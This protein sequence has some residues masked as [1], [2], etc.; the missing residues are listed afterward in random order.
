MLKM[1]TP[2]NAKRGLSEAIGIFLVLLAVFLLLSPT[3]AFFPVAYGLVYVFGLPL[4]YVLLPIL[5]FVGVSFLLKGR[6]S[7]FK[8]GGWRLLLGA[9]LLYLSL[10][11]FL[12]YGG[13]SSGIFLDGE[14]YLTGLS[15]LYDVEMATSLYSSLAVG[16][17]YPL[18]L[19]SALL[20]S[21]AGP[22]LV[23]TVASVLLVIAVVTFVY[24]YALLYI[25]RLPAK[26]KPRSREP[27]PSPTPSREKEEGSVYFAEAP[28]LVSGDEEEAVGARYA[29]EAPSI[30]P[31]EVAPSPLPSYIAP[32][33]VANPGLHE[34][35][36]AFPEGSGGNEE[37]KEPVTPIRLPDPPSKE[38]SAPAAAE[39]RQ[40]EFA[41]PPLPEPGPSI[42]PSD[43]PSPSYSF[44]LDPEPELSA[45]P[46]EKE[47][48]QPEEEPEVPVEEAP[49]DESGPTIGLSLDELENGPVEKPVKEKTPG[50]PLPEEDVERE[51]EPETV[52]EE[53]APPL[54]PY[55]RLGQRK[56]KPLPPYVFPSLDLLK[57]YEDGGDLDSIRSE[58]EERAK[59]ITQTLSD[60]RV[61]ARVVSYTIG[62]SVTRYDIQC[63]P[64][65]PVATIGKYVQDISVRLSGVP[66]RFEEVVRG[67]ATSGLEIANSKTSIVSLREMIEHLPIGPKK[68]LYI[69]FGK[70]ISGEYISADLGEFPHML[71]AGGTGSGKSI[72][73]H[74]IIMS[75]LMRNRPEELKF[76]LIDPKR[77]ELG[78]YRDVPHLLTHMIKD[79]EEAK[80]CLKKLCDEM[81]RRYDLLEE[82][83]ISNIRQFNSDIAEAEGLEKLPFIVVV[84]DEYADLVGNCKEIGD[85]VVRLAQ[86]ARAAGIH[87]VIATQRPSVDIITG[88]IKANLQVRVA[89]RVASSQDSMVILSQGGA[90]DL[91]GYGDM[92]VD[93]SLVSRSGFTR[94][95]GCMVDN[96]EIAAVSDF[97]SS[98]LKCHYDPTFADLTDHEADAKLLEEGMS[99]DRAA[100]KVQQGDDFYRNVVE[101]IIPFD[102]TS[103]SKI[104]RQFGIGFPRAG[105]IFAHLQRD[106]IVSN[107]MVSPQKGCPVLVHTM[108]EAEKLMTSEAKDD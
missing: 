45:P 15:A 92:L 59:T 20:S 103:I 33:R 72:F 50:E 108:E 79:T 65:V 8:T 23:V 18:S 96:R 3:G 93:C 47:G 34:A 2:Q 71:I 38:E 39:E 29:P 37:R 80:V 27:D 6:W 77:V 100:L 66:T 28:T 61:G 68:N 40:A 60:L 26:G 78:K 1:K 10:A 41:P 85:Y 35:R 87:L 14:S 19:L 81:E 107:T 106:G 73:V 94:C 49:E 75:L 53:P 12:A 36:F 67:K 63:D 54:S 32:E 21:L 86:K 52:E 105:R 82:G 44:H 98:Q 102:F 70:S 56:A 74:G 76:I 25:S 58:C 91:N 84:I 57:T 48:K 42:V 30:F 22:Y 9:F 83:R 24:P 16:A 104:Q 64:N 17:G 62:P 89:L 7:L 97:V 51:A 88:V 13:L 46:L 11:F 55:E 99:I 5:V 69:P 43:R 31:K 90:E 95:Q 4:F 101:N